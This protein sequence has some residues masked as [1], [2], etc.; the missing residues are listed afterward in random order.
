MSMTYTRMFDPNGAP[1]KTYARGGPE[2]RVADRTEKRVYE[3]DEGI[4]LQVNVA[5][6]TGRPL[7]VR[8]PSG[9]GKSSLARAVAQELGW[10]YY[11]AVV[12]ARTQARDLLWSFDSVRRL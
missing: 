8:G 11:E 7:L 12:T 5:L 1:T 3:F 9:S 10:R 6:A 4:V 2:K